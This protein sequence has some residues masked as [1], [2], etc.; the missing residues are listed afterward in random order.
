[1]EGKV[2]TMKT[3]KEAIDVAPT[4]TQVEE[5]AVVTEEIA[6]MPATPKRHFQMR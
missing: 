4:T 3:I 5:E 2:T 6:A 1:M